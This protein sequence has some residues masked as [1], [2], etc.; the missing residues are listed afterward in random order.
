MKFEYK[1]PI[2]YP[3]CIRIEYLIVEIFKH[4][5]VAEYTMVLS[6]QVRATLKC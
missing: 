4:L 2:S 3:I 5:L 6:V 1:E